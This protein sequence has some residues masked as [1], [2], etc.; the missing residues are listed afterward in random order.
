MNAIAYPLT[1]ELTKV[2]N[3][4]AKFTIF[5]KELFLGDLS[6]VFLSYNDKLCNIYHHFLVILELFL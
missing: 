2:Y 3:I 1:L 5:F 6:I 4:N